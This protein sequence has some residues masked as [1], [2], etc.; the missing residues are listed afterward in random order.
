VLPIAWT[1]DAITKVTPVTSGVSS[2]SLMKSA[3][4]IATLPI[5]GSSLKPGMSTPTP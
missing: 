5:A 1:V 2:G 4:L 3:C